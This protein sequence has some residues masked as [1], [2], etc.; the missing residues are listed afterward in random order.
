MTIQPP[1][2]ADRAVVTW[3]GP[4]QPIL[5]QVYGPDGEV[6]SMPLTPTRALTLAKDLIEPAVAEIKFQ[7]WGSAE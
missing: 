6:A 7:Q 3:A 2:S 4:G 5:L 1:A